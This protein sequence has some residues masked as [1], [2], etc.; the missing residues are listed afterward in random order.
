MSDA[1]TGEVLVD[2]RAGAS[3]AHDADLL[4]GEEVLTSASEQAHLAVVSGV[5]T[6]WLPRRGMQDLLRL[7]DDD[8]AVEVHALARRHPDVACHGLTS[9]HERSNGRAVKD[10]E[11][12]WIAPAM[13]RHVIVG[14][15][16][17]MDAWVIVDSEVG[18]F[19]VGAGQSTASDEVGCEH[20]VA[21]L[22]RHIVDSIGGEKQPAAQQL[23]P[24]CCLDDG[25]PDDSP[26]L[27]LVGSEEVLLEVSP[28]L[29]W[30][31]EAE[32]AIHS[33]LNHSRTFVTLSAAVS[34]AGF[35]R[36]LRL[37]NCRAFSP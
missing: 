7:A 37:D 15:G 25:S 10:V 24:A 9:K 35:R 23:A 8:C 5:G 17:S 4:S 29:Q 12:S 31:P 3:G 13:R 36:L 11:K 16:D 21:T 30:Q 18:E 19:F 2:E 1:E 26:V 28:Y 14:E 32:G 20:A 22:A 34:V 33:V 6:G 27:V